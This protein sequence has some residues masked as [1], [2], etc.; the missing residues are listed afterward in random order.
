M[1]DKDIQ[2]RIDQLYKDL[3]PLQDYYGIRSKTIDERYQEYLKKQEIKN[4]IPK[5]RFKLP[6]L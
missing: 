2:A 3:K 1:L 5:P 4:N 6:K